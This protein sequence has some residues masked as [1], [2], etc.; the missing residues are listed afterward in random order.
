[1]KAYEIPGMYVTREDVESIFRSRGDTTDDEAKAM[2]AALTEGQMVGIGWEFS[3]QF[4][5]TRDGLF[6]QILRD[7]MNEVLNKE[8]A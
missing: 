7:A 8:E 6:N 2:A 1:M 5:E 4:F 3:F